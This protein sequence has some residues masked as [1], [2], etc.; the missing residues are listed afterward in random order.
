MIVDI[1]EGDITS[2]D[3]PCDIII[4][5][6]SQLEDVTGIGLPFVRN[7]KALHPIQLGSVLTYE[8][9]GNRL[10]HML[11]C[12]HLGKDG[13][14]GADMHVRFGMDYLWQQPDSFSRR[15]S[16]VQ[17]GTGRVGKRDGANRTSIIQA[18][19]NSFLPAELYIYTPPDVV[20][21]VV[22]MPRQT[23][24]PKRAW[25]PRY[26]EEELRIFVA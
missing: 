21:D 15:F 11:I 23:L 20:H 8:F 24:T 12:H 26:G 19:A 4:G 1:V 7:V 5:M 13:W 6:N 3:N 18:M 9:D 22:G 10:V 16:I 25:H 2:P 17:I 14:V